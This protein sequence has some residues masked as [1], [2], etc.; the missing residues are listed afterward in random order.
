MIERYR[1]ALILEAAM[2]DKFELSLL[3][4][5]YGAFLTE[6]QRELISMNA[7]EDLSLSEIA[8]LRGISKQGV[9][10]ALMRGEKQL[11]DMEKKLG[12][13]ERDRKLHGLLEELGAQIDAL[14]IDS[15]EL[16]EARSLLDDLIRITE[17]KD[18]I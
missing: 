18:G 7:N 14:N 3:M 15:T 13:I 10:D 17:G 6:N 8:E 4:D 2:Q 1:T 11:Y 9:R 12:L 5:Y 16:L